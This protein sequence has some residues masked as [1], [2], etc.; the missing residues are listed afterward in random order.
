MLRSLTRRLE[1]GPPL[2][3]LAPMLL[4]PSEAILIEACNLYDRALAGLRLTLP[5]YCM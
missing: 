4:V 2:D 1:M 3:T 5:T